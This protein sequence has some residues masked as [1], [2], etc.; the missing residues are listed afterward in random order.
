MHLPSRSANHRA[1]RIPFLLLVAAITGAGCTSSTGP[2]ENSSGD[3]TVEAR[4]YGSTAR[5][6]GVQGENL[7]SVAPGTIANLRVTN[8]G[9]GKSLTFVAVAGSETLTATCTVTSATGVSEPPQVVVQPAYNVLECV[10]W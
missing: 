9:M 5:S 4:N 3:L 7:T 2:E 6:M 8:P 10:S 1:G